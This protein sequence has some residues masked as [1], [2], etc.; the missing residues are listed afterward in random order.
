MANLQE[1]PL[2][3]SNHPE[4]FNKNYIFRTIDKN[5]L[6]ITEEWLPVVDYE[7]VYE[8]SNFGRICSRHKGWE[9]IMKQ[10]SNR[11]KYRYI[12]LYKEK[13]RKAFLVH[14]LVAFSFIPNSE[15]KP[16][17][18]HEDGI[19][20]NNIFNNINW[21]T[22]SENSQHAYDNGLI[23]LP[24]GSKR[25]HCVLTEEQVI[26]IRNEYD[27]KTMGTTD[28]GRKYGVSRGVIYCVIKRK[29][30]THV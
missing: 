8:V 3:L 10:L 28:L 5:G 9:I 25:K 23:I 24:R 1:L 26:K 29:T 12:G 22:F 15:N 11:R 13:K 18:N 4:Y 19:K 2:E 14:R 30:Y 16:T 20:H 6:L 27:P 17:I 7:G 21:A